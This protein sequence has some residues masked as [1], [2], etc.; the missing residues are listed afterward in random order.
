[1]FAPRKYRSLFCLFG[2]FVLVTRARKA[3]EAPPGFSK[4]TARLPVVRVPT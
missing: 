1:M 4:M 3:L 2:F